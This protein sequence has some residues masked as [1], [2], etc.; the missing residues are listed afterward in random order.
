MTL[1]D[2]YMNRH[3]IAFMPRYVCFFIIIL[4]LIPFTWHK[5]DFLIFPYAYPPKAGGAFV[6]AAYGADF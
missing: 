1:Y 4:V 3:T 2:E 6:G 5:V